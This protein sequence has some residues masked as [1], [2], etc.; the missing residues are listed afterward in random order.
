MKIFSKLNN[1]QEQSL[2]LIILGYKN[3]WGAD[4]SPSIK[5]LKMASLPPNG[6]FHLLLTL[7]ISFRDKACLSPIRE[8]RLKIEVLWDGKH[9]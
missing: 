1:S 5:I 8:N 9:K 7:K 4:Q 3:N 2:A 6:I